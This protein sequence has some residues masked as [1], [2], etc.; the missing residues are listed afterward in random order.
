M[1][2]TLALVGGGALAAGSMI[3]AHGARSRA[4]RSAR[5]AQAAWNQALE[6]YRAEL[7]PHRRRY[8]EVAGRLQEEAMRPYGE[9]V[10]RFF[11]PIRAEHK[12]ALGRGTQSLRAGQAA[13]GIFQSGGGAAQE[14]ELQRRAALN[15]ATLRA[16]T[17]REQQ[18]RQDALLQYI[19]GAED[20]YEMMGVQLPMQE[21]GFNVGQI[22][23]RYGAPGGME[24]FGYGLSGAGSSLAQLALL[25]SL[26]GGAR[27]QGQQYFT[28]YDEYGQPISIPIYTR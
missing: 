16:G 2:L 14:A 17:E 10:E 27:G 7:A 3:G 18:S 24:S 28:D 21:L 6:R 1:P 4:R 5:A 13:R 12:E 15:L 23:R 8:G 25:Q 11:A 20:P 19:H 26:Y 22:E 9:Q